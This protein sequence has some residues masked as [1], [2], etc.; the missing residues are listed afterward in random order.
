ML[1]IDSELGIPMLWR[2]QLFANDNKLYQLGVVRSGLNFV[3]DS[4][5]FL[6]FEEPS[7]LGDQNV[8]PFYIE[9]EVWG[10]PW[11]TG[12]KNDTPGDALVAVDHTGEVG[13]MYGGANGDDKPVKNM[14]RFDMR[15]NE[16]PVGEI[17]ETYNSEVVPGLRRGELVH[18]PNIG[19]EGMLVLVGGEIPRSSL[20][21]K[22][23]AHD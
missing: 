3:N 15:G 13:W 12:L 20:H 22:V 18:L 14:I 19:M 11:G 8:H 9:R 4:G 10:P 21:T 23:S 2:G 6:T 7:S 17:I 5:Y 16:Q 1:R